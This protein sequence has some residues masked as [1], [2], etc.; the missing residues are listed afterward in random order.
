[1]SNSAAAAPHADEGAASGGL[2]TS[3]ESSSGGSRSIIASRRALA[4]EW[5]RALIVRVHPVIFRRRRL[6]GDSLRQLVWFTKY[7]RKVVPV[8]AFVWT[9]LIAIG[10]FLVGQRLVPDPTVTGYWHW[11]ASTTAEFLLWA[12]LAAFLGSLIT[13]WRRWHRWVRFSDSLRTRMVVNPVDYGYTA[14]YL[15]WQN[16]PIGH[17]DNTGWLHDEQLDRWLFNVQPDISLKKKERWMPGG[18][19]KPLWIRRGG[20]SYTF[21]EWKIRL[22]SDFMYRDLEVEIQKTDYASSLVTNYLTLNSLI[23]GDHDNRE[24]TFKTTG[25]LTPSGN[26]PAFADSN[27]SN[28]LGGDLLVIAPGVVWLTYTDKNNEIEPERYHCSASGSFD[29]DQDLF[30]QRYLLDVVETGLRRELSE[31]A[32]FSKSAARL[33]DLRVVRFGRAT[34]A[35]GKPQFLAL[36]RYPDVTPPPSGKREDYTNE[37]MPLRFS[38]IGGLRGLVDSFDHFRTCWNPHCDHVSHAAMPMGGAPQQNT[39]SA[40]QSPEGT[41]KPKGFSR[42]LT[43]FVEL[44]RELADGGGNQEIVTW[45]TEQWNKP[46]SLHV[47]PVGHSLLKTSAAPHALAIGNSAGGDETRT[48]LRSTA[49][50]VTGFC[51]FEQLRPGILCETDALRNTPDACTE[52]ASVREERRLHHDDRA[53]CTVVLLANATAEGLQAAVG[54]ATH[55]ASREGF[56]YLDSKNGPSMVRPESGNVY[57]YRIPGLKPN[58]DLPAHTA[59]YLEQIGRTIADAAVRARAQDIAGR[60]VFHL[61]ADYRAMDPFMIA[62]AH[63]TKSTLER[64]AITDW[65]VS[66]VKIHRLRSGGNEPSRWR[67]IPLPFGFEQAGRN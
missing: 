16:A 59:A 55:Y 25:L 31:E 1:M 39:T 51:L 37:V 56:Y 17:D 4:A 53:D 34:Y 49:D 6:I 2:Q 63:E 67:L 5:C 58:K 23:D 12:S 65:S 40:A 35:G 22:A 26:I 28:H 8:A 61:N 38:T 52:W 41:T 14:P 64:R 20:R 29:W 18:L 42:P 60:I 36:C 50:A 30:G 9:S 47:V 7:D 57:V 62:V 43:M 27:C 3:Q 45:L 19:A 46:R 13:A 66:V 44:L 10:S 48:H 15:N 32:G 11:L 24:L 54:V 21:N 33:G